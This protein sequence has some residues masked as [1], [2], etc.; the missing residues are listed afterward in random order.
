MANYL[1]L[2]TPEWMR[3]CFYQFIVGWHQSMGKT[4]LIY[5]QLFSRSFTK[6]QKVTG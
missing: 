1:P 6:R 4:Q 2:K 5:E 3:D